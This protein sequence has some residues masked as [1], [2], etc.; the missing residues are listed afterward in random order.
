MPLTLG[1]SRIDVIRVIFFATKG[2]CKD[3]CETFW[4][5]AS[6]SL[7][8]NGPEGDFKGDCCS[9]RVDGIALITGTVNSFDSSFTVCSD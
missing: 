5:R 4:V 2:V 7:K 6:E 3:C 1:P 9:A 8:A